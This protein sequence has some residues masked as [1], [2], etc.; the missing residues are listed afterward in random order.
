MAELY[1]TYI[2]RGLSDSE[3]LSNETNETDAKDG[4]AYRHSVR[5]KYESGCYSVASR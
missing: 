5:P 2:V 4:A 3:V 1:P